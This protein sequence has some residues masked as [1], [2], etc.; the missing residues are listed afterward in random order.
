ML[1]LTVCGVKLSAGYHT[2]HSALLSA[3][4]TQNFIQRGT[5]E[6]PEN[7][8]MV[9]IGIAMIVGGLYLAEIIV[10]LVKRGKSDGAWEAFL[11]PMRKGIKW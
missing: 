6:M 9:L 1:A 4:N 10:R 8:R 7:M 2:L 11:A 5:K 3:H